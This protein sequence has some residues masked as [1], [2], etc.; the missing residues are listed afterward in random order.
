MTPWSIIKNLA[1]RLVQND[2][3]N[4]DME[5]LNSWIVASYYPDAPKP[6]ESTRDLIYAYAASL[7]NAGGPGPRFDRFAAIVA[8]TVSRHW[9]QQNTLQRFNLPQLAQQCL[10]RLGEEGVLPFADNGRGN[11]EN[12]LESIGAGENIAPKIMQLLMQSIVNFSDFLI[13]NYNGSA[14]IYHNSFFP[15][16]NENFSLFA[17]RKYQEIGDFPRIGI[18][19]AMNFFKDSQVTGIKDNPQ[20]QLNESAISWFVKPDKHVSR[21]MLYETSRSTQMNIDSTSLA[22]LKDSKC[23]SHYRACLPANGFDRD[24]ITNAAR[25]GIAQWQCIEDVHCWARRENISPLEIDR[26]LYLIG[27]G[28]FGAGNLTTPQLERYRQYCECVCNAR[29]L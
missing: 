12:Q 8:S 10:A 21:L 2:F 9:I 22:T 24:Y 5:D 7:R 6:H 28:R 27:S 26:V 29:D 11:Y 18:A 19:V 3:R 25:N 15:E 1:L 20:C 17:F 14:V 23:F 13:E 16:E 4:I